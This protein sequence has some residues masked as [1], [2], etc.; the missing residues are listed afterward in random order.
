MS[1]GLLRGVAFLNDI[2]INM[3]NGLLRGV[4]FLDLK[5]VF[6]TVNHDILL[7]KLKN[8][9]VLVKATLIHDSLS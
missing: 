3:S 4:A 8:V 9:W 5:K 7:K 1:N 2:Y 6:H